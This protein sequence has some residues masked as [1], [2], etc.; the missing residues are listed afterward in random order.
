MN[1]G[2]IKELQDMY[3]DFE[4]SQRR[5][6]RGNLMVAMRKQHNGDPL[7]KRDNEVIEKFAKYMLDQAL[8]DK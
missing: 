4:K 6:E 7:N 3:N 5:K 2:W 1:L 8:K